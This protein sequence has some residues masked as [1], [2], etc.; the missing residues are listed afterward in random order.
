MI[1]ADHALARRIESAEAMN[2]R[3][4][5]ASRP[6]SAVLE[7][8]GGIAVFLGAESPLTHAAGVGLNGPVREA[9]LAGIE[10][11]FR[12]RGA[13]VS[14]ELSPLADPAF[15]EALG[16]RGYRITE[17]NN[18]LVR[19]LGAF[20][21]VLAPRVRRALAGEDDLWAHALGH[22]FFEKAELTEA[23]MDIGRDLFRA[24]GVICYLA[25]VEGEIAAGAALAIREGLA[26]LCAD[27]TIPSFRRRGLQSELIAA[28]LN[29]AAA[30]G[31]DL[32]TAS[33]LP[34]SQSQRNYERLGFQVA[35]T[36]LTLTG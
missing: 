28:R 11:F 35:Y 14:F 19:R 8:G 6:G 29:E 33:T 21:I 30:Q 12:G 1:L 4:C 3:D 15:I 17:F 16:E 36:K 13:S 5:A 9:E 18:V 24:P 2:A 22:G 23:E 10:A 25:S 26:T 31:C 20:E 32:A 34:G 27:G 7:A